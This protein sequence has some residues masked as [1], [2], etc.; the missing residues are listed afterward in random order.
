MKT[1][2][3]C[4]FRLAVSRRIAT[5]LLMS[6][7]LTCSLPGFCG[8]IHEAARDGDIKK[9]ESLLKA[10]PSLVSSK[11]EQYGQTP[12]HFAAFNDRLEV[13]KLLLADKAD[14]NAKA[15]NGS[16]PLHLAAAKGSKDMV[17][18]LVANKAD[19]NAL[20]NEGWSPAHSAIT[21]GHQDIAD[22]LSQSGGKDVPLSKPASATPAPGAE[23]GPPKETRKDGQFTAYDDGTVLDTKTNLMWSSR[24]NA[25]PLSWPDAKAYAG[26]YRGGGYADWRLPTPAELVGLFDKTKTRKTYC[27]AAVDELGQSVDEVHVTDLI[28]LSCIREWTSQEQSDKAGF[29][30]VVDFHTGNEVSRPKLKEFVDTASRVLLV[31]AGK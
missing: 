14:V 9:V 22:L 15:K 24:D 5:S 29:V 6:V 16:T 26:T 28:R 31:R 17:E 19:V 18:L 20:D 4:L 7:A 12:L 30:T 23:K 10:Q 11:D 1:F 8:P 2:Y 13:A 21:W 3:G 25:S 27:P